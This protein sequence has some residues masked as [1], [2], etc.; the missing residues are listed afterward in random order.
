MTTCLDLILD[1]LQRRPTSHVRMDLRIFLR[2][3]LTIAGRADLPPE[4]Q[5]DLWAATHGLVCHYN[6]HAEH[7]TFT[8]LPTL[9]HP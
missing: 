2:A 5:L 8:R 7:F 1:E 6:A 3:R 4:K 9:T